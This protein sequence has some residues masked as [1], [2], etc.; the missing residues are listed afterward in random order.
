MSRQSDAS[1]PILG[2]VITLVFVAAAPN[3]DLDP[4]ATP[5]LTQGDLDATVTAFRA[6]MAVAIGLCVAGSLLALRG[7]Q[8]APREGRGGEADD[9]R[10][11]AQDPRGE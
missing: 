2:I 7:L 4:F 3:S 9:E 1:T 5:G 8:V 11:V 10:G 6:G